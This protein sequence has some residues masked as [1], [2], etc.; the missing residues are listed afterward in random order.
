MVG[1]IRVAL[2]NDY[3]IVLQGLRALLEPYAPGI[4]VVEL[5]VN[6]TPA[7]A[8]EV[9]LLDTY[10]EATG[11]R[12][13]VQAIASDPSN[14]AIVVF[15]FSDDLAI[16]NAAIAAGACGFISKA[17]PATQIVDGIKAAATRRARHVDQSITARGD[18]S[19][20]P[21]A[22]PRPSSHSARERTAGAAPHGNDEPRA[23]RASV[24]E[25]EHDQDPATQ[26]LLQARRPES[27]P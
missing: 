24:P 2:V 20:A 5:D 19:R 27:R 3:E 12:E 25:R 18:C 15:S 8:V 10:G 16:A 11:M 9:T 26:P 13:Q 1:S 22:R 21:M 14:G 17:T 7:R 23:G 6:A 4:A